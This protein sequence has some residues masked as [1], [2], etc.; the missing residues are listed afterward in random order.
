MQTQRAR[1][2]Y[3]QTQR[4]R[5]PYMHARTLIFPSSITVMKE[6]MFDTY[7]RELDVYSNTG[8]CNNPFYLFVLS[9]CF[10]QRPYSLHFLHSV[11][12]AFGCYSF[13]ISFCFV[14]ITNL[15]LAMRTHSS[16]QKWVLTVKRKYL[17]TCERIDPD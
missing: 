6:T 10:I 9:R 12:S 13:Y 5:D 2:P 1:D 3:T 8:T 7:Y 16:S 17:I 15:C 4:A 11:N 14:S